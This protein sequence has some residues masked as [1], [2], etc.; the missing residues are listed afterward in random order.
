MSGSISIARLAARL[1]VHILASLLLHT[2]LWCLVHYP[3]VLQAV[4]NGGLLLS[5]LS[6]KAGV[7]AMQRPCSGSH[8]L[9]QN[10]CTYVRT[11]LEHVWSFLQKEA[12]SWYQK[13]KCTSWS[14]DEGGSWQGTTQKLSTIFC[15]TLAE[16]PSRTC[17]PSAKQIG[18][19][20]PCRICTASANPII[21]G[22]MY[23]MHTLC[24][25]HFMH[26]TLYALRT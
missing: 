6:H 8:A 10:T 13:T 26:Y 12:L 4:L 2:S 19:R 18:C 7:G 14:S 17:L 16:P 22:R 5:G 11:A 3:G 9:Q 24:T 25:T 23:L 20:T 21:S 15:S 1:R